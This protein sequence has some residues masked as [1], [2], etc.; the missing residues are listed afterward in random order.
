MQKLRFRCAL[1]LNTRVLEHLSFRLNLLMLIRRWAGFCFDEGERRSPPV[2]HRC[3]CLEVWRCAHCWNLFGGIRGRDLYHGVR[4]TP[5]DE[6]AVSEQNSLRTS[7]RYL[8]VAKGKL[9]LKPI[10]S[11]V[12]PT[13]MIIEGLALLESI[14]VSITVG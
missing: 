4:L 6:L 9:C 14:Y 7:P 2:G 5:C 11:L 3:V 1:Q 13:Q 8:P 12:R 10:G